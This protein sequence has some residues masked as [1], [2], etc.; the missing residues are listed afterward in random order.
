MHLKGCSLPVQRRKERSDGRDETMTRKKSEHTAVRLERVIPAPPRERGPWR[1]ARIPLSCGDGWLP[2]ES[3]VRR[4]EVDARVG[5]HFR[6]WHV[7][8]GAEIGGFECEIVELV[9]DE[10]IVFR[11]GFVG[12]E[13]TAGPVFDSLLTITLQAARGGATRLTLMHERLDDLAAAMPDIVDNVKIGSGAGPREARVTL[14]ATERDA[15]AARRRRPNS[16]GFRDAQGDRDGVDESRR[17]RAGAGVCRRGHERRFQTWR[18][19][20]ALL[21]RT[22]DEVGRRERESRWRL[23]VRAPHVRRVRSTLAERVAGR[24]GAGPAV[25]HPPE[26]RRVE[27]AEGAA[28][29]AELE[30]ARRQPRRVRGRRCNAKRATICS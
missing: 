19:A 11:W 18:L 9:P 29:L 16:G 4:A 15:N 10:R 17:R 24:A 8:T 2:V 30:T 28:G 5:G 12:P 20:P 7:E 3:T 13:R 25:E 1:V 26:V 14:G 21:R 6:I 23:P 22:L 27:D